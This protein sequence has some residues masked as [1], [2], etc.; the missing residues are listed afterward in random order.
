MRPVDNYY[1]R[2]HGKNGWRYQYEL[3]ELTE[4]ATSLAKA[5]RG[6]VFFN[7]SKMTEDALKFCQPLDE[8]NI[9]RQGAA[10]ATWQVE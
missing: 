1:F 7:N 2:L 6:C 4:L 5:Q 10:A 9:G 8:L 3:G